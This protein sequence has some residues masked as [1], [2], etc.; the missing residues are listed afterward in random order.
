MIEFTDK[1]YWNHASNCTLTGK[2]CVRPNCTGCI[3]GMKR[4]ISEL[5][6]SG[7]ALPTGRPEK[8]HGIEVNTNVDG[9]VMH[10]PDVYSPSEMVGTDWWWE[11]VKEVTGDLSTAERFTEL[12][13]PY[14]FAIMADG[15]V[16]DH[17]YVNE[18]LPAVLVYD[19]DG[20]YI[21]APR[22]D[23]SGID[24][25]IEELYEVKKR[26]WCVNTADEDNAALAA[27]DETDPVGEV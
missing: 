6:L 21:V 16:P 26:Y 19:G 11:H 5:V 24:K 15:G 22:A 17:V 3:D 25:R 10:I 4:Y 13:Y 27:L 8:Y 7:E 23:D 18:L 14:A 2:H 9:V 1:K 20:M 12:G